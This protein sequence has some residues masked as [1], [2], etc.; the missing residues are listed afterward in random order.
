MTI[1]TLRE[2]G[3]DFWPDNDG[4]LYYIDPATGQARTVIE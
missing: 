1:E 2:M 3:I 4:G